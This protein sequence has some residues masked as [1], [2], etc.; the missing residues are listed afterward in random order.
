MTIEPSNMNINGV[1]PSKRI[2]SYCPSIKE[3]CCTEEELTMLIENVSRGIIEDG[4][5][6][7][8]NIGKFVSVFQRIK[9]KN[10]SDFLK[11]NQNLVGE[12]MDLDDVPKLLQAFSVLNSTIDQLK[13]I[14]TDYIKTAWLEQF[15]L[16]CGICDKKFHQNFIIIEDQNSIDPDYYYRLKVNENHEIPFFI[17]IIRKYKPLKSLEDFVKVMSCVYF[18]S[19]DK[20]EISNLLYDKKLDE[21]LDNNN[22]V[23]VAENN[24][25]KELFKDEYLPGGA[26]DFFFNKIT[27]ILQDLFFSKEYI[28]EDTDI[29]TYW[30]PLENSPS[31]DYSFKKGKV[32]IIFD[33]QGYDST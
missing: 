28:P 25:A 16:Q 29:V 8:E 6:N 5:M 27:S 33:D 22:P 13:V 19:H 4:K 32:E 21:F 11:I 26:K 10:F 17:N 14:Y 1:T 9:T 30:V 24:I 12:C 20:I 3:S 15:R 7:Y 23:A 31:N 18:K 2:R